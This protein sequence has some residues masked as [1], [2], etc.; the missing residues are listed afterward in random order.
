MKVKVVYTAILEREIEVDDK[1]L[2]IPTT[3]E[4]Y[5]H[6]NDELLEELVN[7]CY[8]ETSDDK[9]FSDMN[10]ILTPDKKFLYTEF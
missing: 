10:A 5:S 6:D 1:F 8:R 3:D 7:A 9:N 2:A 4:E